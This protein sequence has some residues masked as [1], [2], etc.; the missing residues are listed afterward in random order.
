VPADI[1]LPTF[2]TYQFAHVGWGHLLGNLFILFLAGPFIEDVWGRPLYAAFYLM[3]GIVAALM[4]VVRYPDFNGPLVGASGAIA[5]VMGAFLVRY[6][7]TKIKFFYWIFF[8]MVGTFEAPAWLM[9]PLWFLKE[10][11]FAGAMDAVS[12]GEGGGGVAFW[13]HVWGFVFGVT[14]ACAIAYFRIEERWIHHSIESKVTLVDNTAVEDAATLA[15]GGDREGAKAALKRELSTDSE[16]VDAAIALWN[17]CF[18]DGDIAT[19]L[20]HLLRAIRSAVRT[21]DTQFVTAHWL[22]VLDSGH[23]VDIDP[24]LATRI[25]EM[26]RNESRIDPAVETVDMAARRVDASTPAGVVLRLARLAIDLGSEQAP[27]LASAALADP[28]LPPE[29]REELEPIGADFVSSQGGEGT[30]ED[31]EKSE[32]DEP[33]V[34]SVVAKRVVPR[35]LDGQTLEVEIDEKRHA[36]D[37]ATIQVIAVCGISRAAEKPVVLVDLLLDSPWGERPKLRVIR[38]T[39]NLF[40]P[41]QLVGG[42]DAMV[43]FQTFIDRLFELSD[44]VPLPDPDAARG[45]PFQSFS[46][47]NE[48]EKE[49]L[50]IG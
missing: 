34:H 41:R 43:A 46:T 45:K 5:G 15:E 10:L 20:P 25:A 1:R 30:P 26:L 42:D 50:G 11:T 47:I 49:V 16:N 24:A 28:D 14:V 44:A 19:P 29:A 12:P 8:F 18:Q 35:R 37:L 7:N 17:L 22:E 13:A 31:T 3:A 4:F 33:I 40:D 38:M 9:L 6:W 27:A 23:S 32:I 21:G 2:I 36:I 39:S 48:Y